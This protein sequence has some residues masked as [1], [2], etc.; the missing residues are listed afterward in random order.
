[1][2]YLIVKILGLLTLSALFGS[3]LGRW[4]L[5]RSYTDVTSEHFGLLNSSNAGTDYSRDFDKLNAHMNQ[6]E[7]GFNAVSYTHLTLPT[8]CSV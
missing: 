7:K 8:I 2:L 5:N 4:F 1:M 6:L 3:W